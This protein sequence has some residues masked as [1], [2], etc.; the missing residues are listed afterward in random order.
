MRRP[1]KPSTTVSQAPARRFWARR[2]ALA[3]FAA[4]LAAPLPPPTARAQITGEPRDGAG[5]PGLQKGAPTPFRI[6]L[7]GSGR[8]TPK[9]IVVLA[10]DRTYAGPAPRDAVVAGGSRLNF[11][12][13]P[14][15]EDLFGPRP[16]TSA[17]VPENRL[18][19]LYR[20]G[21]ALIIDLRN[22][23]IDVGA[24]LAQPVAAISS[25]P[26]AP[27]LEISA[28]LRLESGPAEAQDLSRR[29][30]PPGERIGFVYWLGGS[31]DGRIVL[32]PPRKTL[33]AW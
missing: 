3:S 20:S 31:S 27:I 7:P 15:L 25:R 10:I 1:D 2:A 32:S 21:D 8:F 30:A 19:G 28:R 23:P 17:V 5:G 24:V 22:A 12:G 26:S 11:S 13:T 16:A 18:G 14:L 4:I 6:R 29:D 9:R 33:F